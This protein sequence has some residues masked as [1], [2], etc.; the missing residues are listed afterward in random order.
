MARM[1]YVEGEGLWKNCQGMALP[2]KVIQRPMSLDL[3][4]QFSSSPD[5]PA[6]E[7]AVIKS[8]R[9]GALENIPKNLDQR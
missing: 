9:I 5:E 7:G 2:I 1:V 3:G 4:V 6:T 8:S